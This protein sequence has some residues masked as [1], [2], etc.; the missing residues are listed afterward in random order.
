MRGSEIVMPNS[1]S[2]VLS[3]SPTQKSKRS[4]TV[5]YDPNRAQAFRVAMTEHPTWTI[6]Q[7]FKDGRMD[8]DED[9]M[10][11]ALEMAHDS[12]NHVILPKN[13]A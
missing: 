10:A 4:Q 11:V 5:S 6:R 12:L 2:P 9:L 7:M 3:M 8:D 13:N 1:S